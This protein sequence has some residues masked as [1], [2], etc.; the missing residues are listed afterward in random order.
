M[1]KRIAETSQYRQAPAPMM[2]RVGSTIRI[3]SDFRGILDFMRKLL[4]LAPLLL[5]LTGCAIDSAQPLAPMLP[6]LP[7][8]TASLEPPPLVDQ[9]L[10]DSMTCEP[11]TDGVKAWITDLDRY[12]VNGNAAVIVSVGEGN[13]PGEYWWVVAIKSNDPNGWGDE[14][15]LTNEPSKSQPSGVQ[16]ISVGHK[17]GF[18][19]KTVDWSA[20]LWVGER[21]AKGQAAQAKALT[22]LTK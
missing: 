3:G 21:L 9:R 14:T 2:R 10:V 15:Y 16:W 17:N 12:D 8:P 5:V 13:T 22:C 11:P 18:N 1:K 20:V 19:G 4:A 7:T 6:T